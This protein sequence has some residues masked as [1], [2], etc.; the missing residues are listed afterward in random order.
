MSSKDADRLKAQAAR[1]IGKHLTSTSGVAH[2]STSKLAQLL[3]EVIVHHAPWTSEIREQARRRITDEWLERLENYQAGNIGP[4]VDMILAG[5]DPPDEIAAFL[6]ESANPTG[7]FGSLAQSFLIYGVGFSVAST[8]MQPFLQEVANTLWA[9]NTYKPLDPSILATMAVR[10]IDPDTT[11]ITPV[12]DT[13]KAIAAMTGLS[14]QYM[15]A[16]VDATG[17]PPSPQDLFEMFRRSIID[18]EDLARGLREGDTRDEWIPMFEKLAYTT[19]SPIDMVRAAVQEQLDYATAND[20][21]TQLGLEPPGYVA[22]NPDWFEIMFHIAGRPPGPVE[23]G[24]AANRGIIPWAGRGPEALTFEQAIA[25]SDIKTKWT[26]VLQKM[27]AYWPSPN[28]T[29]T[30][31]DAGSITIEQAHAYWQAAGLD[32]TLQAAFAHQATIQQVAQERALAKGSVLEALYDMVIDEPTA[33]E[34]LGD[35]GY[36]GKTAQ[37][38]VDL[39][40]ARRVVRAINMAVRKIGSLYVSFKITANDAKKAITTLGIPDEQATRLLEVWEI[41]RTPEVR[42]PTIG[43][44]AHAVHYSG[45]PFDDAVEKAELLGYTHFDATLVIAAG[46]QMAP[47]GGWPPIDNTGVKV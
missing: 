14:P 46:A 1:L 26:D 24:H 7:L 31:Y 27:A 16:M 22:D 37:Y 21:A 18:L 45:L 39:T 15:Q 30:L 40:L 34:L 43:E 5:S 13:I 23:M 36:F 9:D 25:E 38:M 47:P 32:D 12:S 4:I 3:G 29:R 44:L 6:R 42:L 28:E 17:M 10:G 41:E 2:Q 35:V 33:I 19:P 20:L 8:V 11:K